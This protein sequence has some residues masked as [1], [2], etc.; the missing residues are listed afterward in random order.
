MPQN[1]TFSSQS[2]DPD[3]LIAGPS[4]E[5]ISRQITLLLGQNLTRGALLGKTATAGT[6][7]AAAAAGN[8][9]NG[10]IGTLSVGAAAKEGRYRAVCI[11]PG[12][13]VGTFAVFDPEGVEVGTANVAVAFAGPVGFTIAD[14]ATDFI[15][16]DTFNI[17]VSAVTFKHKLSVFAA[18]DGSQIP[19]AILVDDTDATAADKVTNAY[20]VGQFNSARVTY[21]AGHTALTVREILR[22]KGIHLLDVIG[23]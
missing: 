2:Y 18:V 4:D 21:G 7:A 1:A 11:E 22:A 5:L 12:A 16:G 3:R 13:N 10:A 19:D 14:G 15:S 9:G 20:T 23:A 6:I 17:D 8:T